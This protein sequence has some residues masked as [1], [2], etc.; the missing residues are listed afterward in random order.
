MSNKRNPRDAETAPSEATDRSEPFRRSGSAG[1]YDPNGNWAA[2]RREGTPLGDIRP[3]M[4]G[5][6]SG[7]GDGG[8]GPEGGFSED[9][10]DEAS[11]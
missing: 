9:A 10:T 8:F 6:A 7:A 3:G 4:E 1:E 5:G 2:E 11:D